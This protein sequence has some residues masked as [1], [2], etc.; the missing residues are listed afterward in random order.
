MSR[1]TDADLKKAAAALRSDARFMGGATRSTV[2]QVLALIDPKRYSHHPAHRGWILD[3]EEKFFHIDE[4]F[5][6]GVDVIGHILDALNAFER[7]N[8]AVSDA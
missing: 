4:A 1:P 3:N 6:E 5:N 2:E 7:G 8:E